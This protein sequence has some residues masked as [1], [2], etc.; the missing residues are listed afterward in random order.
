MKYPRKSPNRIKNNNNW[1]H[2]KKRDIACPQLPLMQSNFQPNGDKHFNSMG[3][4]YTKSGETFQ[5]KMGGEGDPQCA[6]KYC[7][8][9]KAQMRGVTFHLEN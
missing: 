7:C 8:P 5:E 4:A 6:T 3:Q 2:H 9:P 1:A